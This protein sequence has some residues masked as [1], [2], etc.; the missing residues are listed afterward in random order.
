MYLPPMY[1]RRDG[2]SPNDLPVS[3]GHHSLP[4]QLQYVVSNCGRGYAE[5]SRKLARADGGALLDQGLDFLPALVRVE[6]STAPERRPDSIRP[7]EGNDT[8]ISMHKTLCDELDQ[9]LPDG[10]RGYG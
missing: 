3:T 9:I 10:F 5:Y 6:H 8:V 1:F 7:R 4:F 2:R